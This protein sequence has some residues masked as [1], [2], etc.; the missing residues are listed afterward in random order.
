MSPSATTAAR[1]GDLSLLLPEW[2]GYG[3]DAAVAHAARALAAAFPAGAFLEVEAPL[4]E[5]L[6]LEA[7]VIGLQALTRQ[8]R[9][10]LDAISTRQPSRIFTI[11]GTC[12]AELGPVAYL[13]ARYRGDLA[14][15][16][17]DAHGDLNTPE[18][19]PSAHFHGMV[20]RTLLGAGPEALVQLI[21]RHLGANQIILAGV[22]ELDRDEILFASDAAVTRLS[23]AD[24]LVPDRV[25]G[26]V[27]AAGF[28]K[29]YVH[30]DLDVLDPV[31]FP[32]S[33]MRTPGG[34]TVD[35]VVDTIRHLD[36]SFDVVGFSVVEFRMRTA[37]A[38]A[39]L[40]RLIARCGIK[41]GAA[42]PL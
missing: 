14:V 20:L 37:D 15:V 6:P 21:S 7:G 4:A 40:E 9:L 16:W 41:I 2:Q 24:L 35:Q 12:G 28:T 11:A 27:R 10:T 8:A 30:L 33:L 39:R 36:A 31:E 13:N 42:G 17:L 29:V 3:V 38:V 18:T 5:P 32:D 23:P 22:R 34:P 1:P 19:S 26:R 25:S